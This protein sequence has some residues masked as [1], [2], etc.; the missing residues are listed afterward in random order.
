MLPPLVKT[1]AE[2]FTLAEVSADKA[3][4]GMMNM[5]TIAETGATSLI[6]FKASHTGRGTHK[7][8]GAENGSW[9]KAFGYF[10][11]RRAEFMEMFELGIDPIFWAELTVA[12][13]IPA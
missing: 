11:F 2:H 5:D 1:T 9:A 4:A 7:N 13:Q 6:P 10:M 12:Q 3:Y 8:R